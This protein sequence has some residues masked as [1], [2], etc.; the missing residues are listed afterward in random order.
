MK[1]T[2]DEK[3]KLNAMLFLLSLSNSFLVIMQTLDQPT[4]KHD[5]SSYL[6]PV[7]SYLSGR[8]FFYMDYFDIKPPGIYIFFTFWGRI[9]EN[10]LQSL[11]VLYFAILFVFF[12]YSLRIVHLYTGIFATFLF[13]LL[14]IPINLASNYYNMFFPIEIPCMALTIS[15]VNLLIGKNSSRT[16]NLLSASFLFSAAGLIKENFSLTI[17]LPLLV[18]VSSKCYKKIW[19][20]ILTLT[21]TYVEVLLWLHHHGAVDSY[22]EVFSLK[23]RLFPIPTYGETVSR[24]FRIPW[25]FSSQ[26]LFF[27]VRTLGLI[28]ILILFIFVKS[29][30]FANPFN[31]DNRSSSC[32]LFSLLFLLACG[33]IL[34]GK[35]L[36]GHYALGLNYFVVICLF[37]FIHGLLKRY[38]VGYSKILLFLFALTLIPNFKF[39]PD[40]S[41]VTSSFAKANVNWK[42]LENYEATSRYEVFTKEECGQ[43]AYGWAS[44]AYYLYSGTEPCSKYFLVELISG[45]SELEAAY[46]EQLTN[47][48]PEQVYYDPAQAGIDVK[49]FET[50]TFNWKRILDKC[51][52]ETD[53]KLFEIMTDSQTVNRMCILKAR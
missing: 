12:F 38:Q 4:V 27:G 15:G 31:F 9:F 48:P 13:G 37:I 22:L 7:D 21:F 43:V 35:P 28:A 17:I 1:V 47:T 2:F 14:L 39:M 10:S 44:G 23:S 45:D 33:F 19:I 40:S 34:Q 46:V 36:F 30:K 32:V 41:K 52:N 25:E 16:F 11:Y 20:P 50:R 3:L 6:A 51:Y 26:Y 24:A 5:L 18:A 42:S 8:G 53:T 29:N 49:R